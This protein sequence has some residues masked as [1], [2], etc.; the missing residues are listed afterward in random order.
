LRLRLRQPARRHLPLRR[1]R[2]GLHKRRD[3]PERG[4]WLSRGPDLRFGEWRLG[5]WRVGEWWV[6]ERRRRGRSCGQGARDPYRWRP[7]LRFGEWRLGEWRFGEWW[8]GERRLRERS[9]VDGRRNQYRWNQHRRHWHGRR[10]TG[11]VHQ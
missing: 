4:L 10:S 6:G 9:C 8:F 2:C 3:L 7:D 11:R 1:L 5:E